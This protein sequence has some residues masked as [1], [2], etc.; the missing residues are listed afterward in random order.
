MEPGKDPTIRVWLFFILLLALYPLAYALGGSAREM[1][2]AYASVAVHLLEGIGIRLV[3]PGLD[4]KLAPSLYQGQI[5]IC[6]MGVAFHNAYVFYFVIK[7]GAVLS[8]G[9]ERTEERIMRRLNCGRPMAIGIMRLG[10]VFFMI[11]T[12]FV[13]V[14]AVA[15]MT[16]GWFV[17]HVNDLFTLFWFSAA[18]FY[19]PGC[20]FAYFVI[21]V[22][23]YLVRDIRAVVRKLQ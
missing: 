9:Y 12:I 20:L 18:F 19:S 17:F 2:I 8:G 3:A 13:S 16:F 5:C 6:L 7:T 4:G 22:T 21:G 11:P 14:I 10:I 1:T 15:N 23:E